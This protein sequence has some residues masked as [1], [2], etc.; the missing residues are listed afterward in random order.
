MFRIRVELREHPFAVQ[1]RRFFIWWTV[2]RCDT[3][4]LARK[5]VGQL[6]SLKPEV[7]H[8]E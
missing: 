5:L 1:R 7:L 4:A 2:G 8:G 3:L 6:R